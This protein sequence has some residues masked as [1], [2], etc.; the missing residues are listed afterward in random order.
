MKRRI[1]TLIELLVVIAIIA[2]LASMLLPALNKAR[3]RAKAINCVANAKQL[4]VGFGMYINDYDDLFPPLIWGSLNTPGCWK[5]S[6]LYMMTPYI[7][8]Q[9]VDDSTSTYASFKKNSIFKCPSMT[10]SRPG[11]YYGCGYAY[12]LNALG[13]ADYASPYS[14]YGHT[15]PGYPV[16]IGKLRQ[17]SRQMLVIDTKYS[18]AEPQNGR[19]DLTYASY[20][21]FRHNDKTNMLM[22]DGH[23]TNAG[24]VELKIGAAT[25]YIISVFPFNWFLEDK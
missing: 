6:W 21:A 1:F 20:I 23:V 2:I 22:A 3:E 18:D 25:Y 15:H 8:D 16:Q 10:P 5:R 24:P 13:K 19:W 9:F 7:G 17:P 11:S 12:N 14:N 4:G